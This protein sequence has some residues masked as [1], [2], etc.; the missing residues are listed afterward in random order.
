MFAFY[1]FPSAMV[2]GSALG[3]FVSFCR[4]DVL[5]MNPSRTSDNKTDKACSCNISMEQV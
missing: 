2:F 5:S 4:F 3:K 1:I